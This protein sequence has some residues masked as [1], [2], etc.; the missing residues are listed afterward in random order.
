MNPEQSAVEIEV[1]GQRIAGTLATPATAIPGVLFVHGWGGS[2]ERDLARARE[3]AALGCVCLTFDLRGHAGTQSQFDCVTRDDNL[4]DALA[5]YDLLINNPMVDRS[6][7]AVVGSS[8]GGYLATILS[9]RRPVRWMAL[10]VP[11]LY[12]DDEWDVPKRQLDRAVLAAYRRRPVRPAEN[13]ALQAC[14]DFAGDVLIVESEHD[15][16]VPHETIISYRAALRKAH[17]V[18]Y[19]VIDGADHALS[20]PL[21]RQAYSSV[22]IGWLTEMVLGSRRSKSL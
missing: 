4:R 19:R 21:C 14:A 5:A 18:T 10:R 6:S 12:K 16:L 13:C 20:E 2:Q 1:D 15:E 7:I 8:Y 22:L 17:S 11:A 3:I 9:S